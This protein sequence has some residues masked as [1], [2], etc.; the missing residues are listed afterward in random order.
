[1][2][3]QRGP[4]ITFC[5]GMNALFEGC[6]G[7]KLRRQVSGGAT[8]PYCT[9]F[10]FP[11]EEGKYV[12]DIQELNGLYDLSYLHGYNLNTSAWASYSYF[13]KFSTRTNEIPCA[14][15][16]DMRGQ[17]TPERY[18]ESGI[19]QAAK[20]QSEDIDVSTISWQSMPIS[21]P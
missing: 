20:Q 15:Y 7:W 17:E 6:K 14:A 5:T 12:L 10:A 9:P 1:M 16:K 18:A 2:K 8:S 19:D 11:K 4:E 13:L 21:G 3:E